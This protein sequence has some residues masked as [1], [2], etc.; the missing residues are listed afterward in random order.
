MNEFAHCWWP[1]LWPVLAGMGIALALCPFRFAYRFAEVVAT[2]RWVWAWRAFVL[3]AILGQLAVIVFMHQC[4]APRIAVSALW[5]C[6]IGFSFVIQP[7][8]RK[9]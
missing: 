6:S 7:L 2:T 3:V 4:P 5:A 1:A 9:P 8:R